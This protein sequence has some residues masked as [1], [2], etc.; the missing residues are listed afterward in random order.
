[1]VEWALDCRNRP[2][3]PRE[4]DPAIRGP[5]APLW[6]HGILAP[7]ALLAA[8]ALVWSAFTVGVARGLLYAGSGDALGLPS[9]PYSDGEAFGAMAN[10]TGLLWWFLAA[11][12]VFVL[13]A[14]V[15]RLW[16]RPAAE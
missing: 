5:R 16:R 11:L 15:W 1:V 14:K 13:V 10:L 12:I 2:R 7:M 3:G 4:Y 8:L 6:M 9:R